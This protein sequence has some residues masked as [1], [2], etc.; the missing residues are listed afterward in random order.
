MDLDK[1]SNYKK[2][3][4]SERRSHKNTNNNYKSGNFNGENYSSSLKNQSK[5]AN[6][7]KYDQKDNHSVKH[8][9][10]KLDKQTSKNSIKFYS[11]FDHSSDRPKRNSSLNHSKISNA[12]K[13]SERPSSRKR[14]R[15][16]RAK[17]K[18]KR[19]SRSRYDSYKRQNSSKD[20]EHKPKERASSGYTR[21]QSAK[22]PE[23]GLT[24]RNAPSSA[25]NPNY[26]YKNPDE[27]HKLRHS[28]A[29]QSKPRR[30]SSA[31]RKNDNPLKASNEYKHSFL[32][33]V[34]K[35]ET[36][37]R[38]PQQDSGA[39]YTEYDHKKV[40]GHESKRSHHDG[41]KRSS[42]RD[43]P[44]E[45]PHNKY[46]RGPGYKGSH[47]SRSRKDSVTRSSAKNSETDNSNRHIAKVRS[48]TDLKSSSK[49]Q[50]Y[51]NSTSMKFNNILKDMGVHSNN[52]G[53]Q[54]FNY[55]DKIN[56]KGMDF[57]AM[58]SKT[59]K[60]NDYDVQKPKFSSNLEASIKTKQGSQGKSNP[61]IA[62][63]F[64]GQSSGNGDIYMMNTNMNHHHHFAYN[65][66]TAKVS[67]REQNRDQPPSGH[68]GAKSS[69]GSLNFKVFF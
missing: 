67:S 15:E 19:S 34:S 58:G 62:N 40:K 63:M 36:E 69:R 16:E 6:S 39:K 4:A 64:I 38:Q 29:T 10:T 66:G 50:I 52:T 41:R 21:P 3:N 51:S 46:S 33:M 54:M 2:R 11:R 56:P 65:A 61:K 42:S 7:Y 28:M 32:D 53:P 18:G 55:T 68:F 5:Y 9:T 13:Q 24:N 59:L 26:N 22:S 45:S 8:A 17:N 23:S 35:N 14:E 31:K 49:P 37:S 47:R 57:N 1:R 20:V 30:P 25:F 27:F 48:S 12:D 43:K 60:L 44:K